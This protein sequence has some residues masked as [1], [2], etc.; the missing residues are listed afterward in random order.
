MHG[1]K[2]PG[3]TGSNNNN[4]SGNQKVRGLVVKVAKLKRKRWYVPKV[5]KHTEIKTVNTKST[6]EVKQPLIIQL[7]GLLY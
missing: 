4:I 5:F 1:C 2:K 7:P 3:R 6:V